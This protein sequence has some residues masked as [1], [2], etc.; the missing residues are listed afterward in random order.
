[1]RSKLGRLALAGVIASALW[2]PAE[3]QEITPL[4]PPDMSRYLRWGPF[5]VR[6]GIQI[7]ALGYDSNVFYRSTGNEVGDYY[8]AIAPTINGVVLFGHRAF[9]TFDER[10]EFYAYASQHDLNYFNQFGRAR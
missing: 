9:L 3:A 8:V 6:P 5:R 10:L 4:E 7:P 1:M 2:G